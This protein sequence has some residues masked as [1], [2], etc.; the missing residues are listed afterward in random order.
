MEHEQAVQQAYR[1]LLSALDWLNRFCEHAP[2]TFGGE[3]ELSVQ[4]D[5]A[6]LQM[7]AQWPALTESSNHTNEGVTSDAS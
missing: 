7:E 3:W 2:I 1:A 5:E 6:R 4:L